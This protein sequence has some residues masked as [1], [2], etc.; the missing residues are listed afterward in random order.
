MVYKA[1]IPLNPVTKKNNQQICINKK[2]GKRFVKQSKRYEEYEE[3]AGY[4]LK[5]PEKPID[6]PVNLTC[7]FY[8]ADKRL[9][10]VSNL[11]EAIQDILVECSVLKDDNHT[12]VA[13]LDG[14][15]VEYDK[16]NPRTEIFITEI[17]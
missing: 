13:G 3:V 11:I 9:V 2:T 14:C 7:V 15:R 5:R 1:I 4:F 10:D 16:E 6:Y 17:V 8:R 12:I